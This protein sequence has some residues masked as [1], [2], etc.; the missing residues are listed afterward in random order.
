VSAVFVPV[1]IVIAIV[2]FSSWYFIFGASF[3]FA[4]TTAVSV[5]VIA[6]PCALGLATPTA[7]MVGTGVGAERGILIKG[8]E[9]LETTRKVSAVLFDKTGTLT[10]GKPAVTDV[11]PLSG[12]DESELLSLAASVEANSEHSLAD[13]I[14]EEAKERKLKLS[15]VMGFKAIPGKGVFGSIGKREVYLGNARL[16]EELGV[17]KKKLAKRMNGL[18]REG[19]TVMVLVCGGKKQPGS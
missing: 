4:L 15:K 8:A 18:E 5:L 3:P 12:L 10:E 11:V 1:V 14:V 19:K 17:E 16:A 6:C 2:T 9:A 13:A 7:I